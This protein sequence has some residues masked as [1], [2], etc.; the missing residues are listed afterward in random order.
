MFWQNCQTGAHRTLLYPER[1]RNFTVDEVFVYP[2]DLD[3]PYTPGLKV[4]KIKYPNKLPTVV[5]YIESESLLIK[6][7]S[8][9]LD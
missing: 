7:G 1:E 3:K 8:E 6:Y 2:A 4:M 9:M 5:F